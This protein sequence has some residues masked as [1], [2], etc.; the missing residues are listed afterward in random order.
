MDEDKILVDD[1]AFSLISVFGRIFLIAY[2]VCISIV[3]LYMLIAMMKNSYEKIMVS[4]VLS[5]TCPN[6][7]LI[8]GNSNLLD[9]HCAFY[10]LKD[11]DVNNTPL[12]LGLKWLSLAC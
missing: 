3:A 6:G 4:P 7:L 5:K 2:V 12:R 9:F 10:T 8:V 1:P 11:C